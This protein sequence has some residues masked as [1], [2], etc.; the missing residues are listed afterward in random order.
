VL[1]VFIC[2]LRR[3]DDLEDVLNNA[4]LENAV[5]LCGSRQR[6]GGIDLN[7]PGLKVVFNENVIAVQL[8]AM[9]VINN[10]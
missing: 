5:T 6:R 2:P 9:L 4:H 1:A 3:D 10:D 8:K 7:K